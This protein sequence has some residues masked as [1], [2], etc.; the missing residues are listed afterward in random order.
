MKSCILYWFTRRLFAIFF[1]L[2][3]SPS[4]NHSVVSSAICPEEC[5]CSLYVID[6]S[7][8]LLTTVPTTNISYNA[9]KFVLSVN[10]LTII[11]DETF[12]ELINLQEL[13]LNHNTIYTLKPLAFRGLN[14]LM[15]L[16][17]KNNRL[18]DI[19]AIRNLPTLSLLHIES[20]FLQRFKPG[21]FHDNSMDFNIPNMT[22][23]FL[24][25]LILSENKI[26]FLPQDVFLGI[27]RVYHVDLSSNR[28]K[29]QSG[30]QPD[31]AHQSVSVHQ[32]GSFHPSTGKQPSRI[33]S[34]KFSTVALSDHLS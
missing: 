11:E 8:R 9:R 29:T 16:S 31:P 21:D 34:V 15:E 22:A 3:F 23:P 20:N 13:R 28:I 7:N 10:H 4:T 5:S 24:N 30:K 12:S 6:C 17:L 19:S 25:S 1:L 18:V 32:S 26:A 27:P 2:I 14:H 33:D